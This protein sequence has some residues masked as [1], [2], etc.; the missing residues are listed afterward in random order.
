MSMDASVQVEVV[1]QAG[2]LLKSG[3][4]L[5]VGLFILVRFRAEF[6]RFLSRL[7]EFSVKTPAG[8]ISAV[9]VAEAGALL[10]VAQTSKEDGAPVTP[11]EKTAAVVAVGETVRAAAAAAPR[12]R[13]RALLWVDD[14]PSNNR[15]EIQALQ[16]L[17]IRVETATSTEEALRRLGVSHYDV[18][19]TDLTRGRDTQ[20]G[21]KF[22]ETARA[23]HPELKIIVY[24]SRRGEPQYPRARELG[25]VG[26]TYLPTALVNQVI[27]ALG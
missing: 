3:L 17:G 12:L 2:E 27:S 18:A 20:A 26:A 10:G 4:W 15:F 13:S 19:I 23:A 7:R 25:A 14:N 21:L 22:I 8:E 6:G 24:S 16:A 1:K 11:E 5:G 9:A